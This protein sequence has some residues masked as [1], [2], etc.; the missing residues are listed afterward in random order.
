MESPVWLYDKYIKE[1]KEEEIKYIL[2]ENYKYVYV[3]NSAIKKT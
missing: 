2:E 3:E 1:G